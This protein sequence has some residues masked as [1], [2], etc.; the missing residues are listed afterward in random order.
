MRSLS[1]RMASHVDVRKASMFTVVIN[2]LQ[3]LMMIVVLLY[4]LQEDGGTPSPRMMRLFVGVAA[5]VVATGAAFD[6][7]DAFFLRRMVTQADTMLDTIDNMESLNNALRAQRHDFRNHL[8]VVYSLIEMED[9]GE[10]NAYIEKVYGAITALSKVM[11]TANPAVNALL[12]VKLTACEKEGIHTRVD[13]SSPWK[14]LPVPGWEMCKVLSNLIDNAMDALRET[15][16]P[17]LRVVLT[18]DLH[19]YRF[20]VANNGPMIPLNSQQRIFQAG[21]TSKS[22]GHGMGLF[23]VRSTLERHGGGIRLQ[24]GPEETVFEGWV[25]KEIVMEGEE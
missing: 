8:Q 19:T 20:T 11:K 16:I 9:Y 2:S 18:E 3:I 12:Q 5:A 15:E 1:S 17:V 24:S 7:R 10:A 25:P 13:I 4:V 22:D 23:I 21:F 14:N 6:I